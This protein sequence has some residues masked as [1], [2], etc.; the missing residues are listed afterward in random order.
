MCLQQP[1]PPIALNYVSDLSGMKNVVVEFAILSV[2]LFL[3]DLFDL[4][5]EV[6]SQE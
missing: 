1:S 2:R 6:N 3:F 5:L 4:W